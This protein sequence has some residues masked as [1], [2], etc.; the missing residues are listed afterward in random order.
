M[1]HDE[2]SQLSTDL[3]HLQA[4]EIEPV[5]LRFRDRGLEADFRRQ[6]FRDN[7]ANI[8]VA[9]L[10]GAVLF[11]VWGLVLRPHIL[12]VQDKQVDLIVRYGV[13]IPMLLV[14]L[15]FSFTGWFERAWEWFTT[16]T[17][18]AMILIWVYYVS[19]V[20]TMPPQYGYVGIILITAFTFTLIRLRF[21]FVVLITAAGIAAY[22]PYAVGA[23]YIVALET[24]LASLFLGTFAL[25]GGVVAYR[26]ERATRLLFLRERQ[27]QYEHERS[28][29]LL[30]NILP[31]AIV[32]RLKLGPDGRVADALDEVSVVFADAVASTA[33]AALTT[34]ERF[35]E[36]LDALFRR[37]DQ[38]AD[39][40]RLEK[41]KTIG[42][43]YMAVAGAPVP[44]QD[45]AARA[46]S[47]ALDM[48]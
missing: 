34:P 30:L 13:F 11:V 16:W 32:D 15:A 14:G 27:L 26:S 9:Y 1:P 38:I 44:V 20:Q 7:L 35:A 3:T 18:V 36:T 17:V 8:R 2:N 19:L 4:V 12:A 29:G 21:L 23:V 33:H 37:F 41:I 43:A 46:A 6:F 39:R 45:H 42:D 22:L 10:G 40:H 48:V 47:A 5:T 28:E 25:L 24:V 31:R